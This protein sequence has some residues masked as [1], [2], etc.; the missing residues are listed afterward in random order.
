MNERTEIA[1]SYHQRGWCV[2][3]VGKNKI[4]LISWKEYHERMSTEEEIRH[5]FE[6]PDAQIGIVTGRISNLTVIDV[7]KDGDPDPFST[8]TTY[9]VH[10]G[11]GGYHFYFQ[12]EPDIHNA[13]RVMPEVDVRSEGGYVIAGGSVSE[14]GPYSVLEDVEVQRMPINLHQIFAKK[15]EPVVSAPA[16]TTPITYAGEAEGGRND[17]LTRYTGKILASM[18]PAL[19]ES[20]ALPMILEANKKNNPPLPEFEVKLI[21]KSISEREMPKTGERRYGERRP[22]PTSLP[23]DDRPQE[24]PSIITLEEAARTQKIDVDSKVTTNIAIFDE[25]LMGGFSP[26]DLII[27][28]GR[29]GV[30]KTTFAQDLTASYLTE[31]HGALWFSYE[32]MSVPLFRKFEEMQLE[33]GCF[34]RLF[35]PS[36]PLSSDLQNIADTIRAAKENNGVKLSVVD[37]IGFIDPDMGAHGNHA[38]AVTH[39]VR[40]L[41]SIAIE[42]ETTVIL[43]VHVRKVDTQEP[44][45]EDVRD[46]YGVVQEADAVFLIDRKRAEAGEREN[47]YYGSHVRIMLAKNRVTG[48]SKSGTFSLLNGRFAYQEALSKA[49]EAPKLTRAERKRMDAEADRIF[50]EWG[51]SS[52][53]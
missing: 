32:V 42:T 41:K 15:P 39:I 28:A 25:A 19:W 10:T 20:V 24:V 31:G 12:Y 7:E 46:S 38:L 22:L 50:N 23:K 26:G 53:D 5:W 33:P 40:A 43:P 1:L 16:P 30:G 48:V 51:S 2:I 27:I 11:S 18:S 47:S 52:D 8:P 14:K 36:P 44:S 49:D 29:S 35:V 4:P 6:R 17:S 21:F 37:H 34:E 13:V 45:L 3:P 9:T